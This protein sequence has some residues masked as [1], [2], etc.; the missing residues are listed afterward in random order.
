[1]LKYENFIIKNYGGKDDFMSYHKQYSPREFKRILRDN[2]FILH[3]TNGDHQIY[4]KDGKHISIP[5]RRCNR[6]LCQRLI[7]EY[8]LNV[9]L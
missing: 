6:M 9:N 5:A 1:M 7:K 8:G 4:Y 3:R 2:G